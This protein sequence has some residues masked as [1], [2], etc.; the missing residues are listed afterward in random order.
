MTPARF[1]QIRE[2]FEGASQLPAECR[3]RYI[4]NLAGEDE[5]LAAAVEGMIEA[6]GYSNGPLDRPAFQMARVMDVN[7]PISVLGQCLG[8]YRVEKEIG[9][10][11]MGTV[12]LAHRADGAFRKKVAIKIARDDSRG[13]DV[14]RRFQQEREILA[15]LDHPNI[16]GLLDAGTTQDGLPYFVMEHVD[17]KPI[18][19]Y[20]DEQKLSVRARLAL[21]RAACAAVEYA[22][23]RY[24]IHRDLKPQNILVTESGVVKLL[25][26]GI[27]KLLDSEEDGPTQ[28]LTRTGFHV[29]TPE[30]ASPEQ[31]QGKTTTKATDVYAL[32]TILYELLTG[33]RPYH[34]R[35]R[36]L[37][38][39]MRAVC[40]EKPVRP[41]EATKGREVARSRAS[42]PDKLKRLLSGNLD[43][44]VLKA[45]NKDP[46]D[47]YASPKAL[48]DD[49][50]S[51]ISRRSR[52]NP[53]DASSTLNFGGPQS[54]QRSP[55]AK[56]AS[57][58]LCA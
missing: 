6:A 29:M 54:R 53:S 1:R 34:M 32:G 24:V 22:H 44:I 48:C 7:T 33:E 9:H 55:R 17:G 20:C 2:V 27:A 46:A 52:L 36:V 18:D 47:R 4:R 10:G 40:E 57:A 43:D 19:E 8:P 35:G 11:G 13:L 50:G 39:L 30:Y 49:L 16:A 15:G 51:A 25:D 14:Q 23:S 12:Y 42:T 56:G 28:L 58:A 3:R 26:F 37:H 45:L 21:F 31:M 38:E 5:R 41:S